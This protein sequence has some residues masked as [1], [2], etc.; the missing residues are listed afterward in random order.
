MLVLV[1]IVFTLAWGLAV[2]VLDVTFPGIHVLLA[3]AVAAVLAH[4]A[5]DRRVAV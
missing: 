2:A 4:A 5:A 3:L 1:A